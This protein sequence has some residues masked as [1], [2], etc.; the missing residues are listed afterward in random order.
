MHL[1]TA[2]HVTKS[3]PTSANSIAWLSSICYANFFETICDYG[4][5]QTK[6]FTL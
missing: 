5:F 4:R 1:R 2:V 3:L 6:L